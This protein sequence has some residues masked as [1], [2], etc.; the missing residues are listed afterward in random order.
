MTTQHRIGAPGATRRMTAATRRVAGVL[1]L[2]LM[3]VP[4]GAA[5]AQRV[6]PVTAGAGSALA[7]GAEGAL[8]N[9]ALLALEPRREVIVAG[10][11]AG[12]QSDA[13]SWQDYTRYNGK[14]WTD[15]DKNEIL[16]R[17]GPDGVTVRA[18]AGL[19]AL[20]VS[21]GRWAFATNTQISGSARLPQDAARL[22][23]FGNVEDKT[24]SLDGAAGDG[25]AWSGVQVGYGLP[26][27]DGAG[28]WQWTAGVTAKYVKGWGYA[29]ILEATGNLSTTLDGTIGSGRMAVRTARGGSGYSLDLGLAAQAGPRQTWSLSLCEAIS[30]VSWSGD[31]QLQYATFEAVDTPLVDADG[32]EDVVAD[33]TWSVPT[34]GFDAALPRVA[35]L[36]GAFPLGRADVAASLSVRFGAETAARTRMAAG[37]LWPLSGLLSLGG[38]VSVGGSEE[39]SSVAG[40][41]FKSA[42]LRADLALASRGTPLF[43]QARGYGLSLGVGFSY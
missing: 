42:R 4:F 25:L 15:A 18:D 22:L 27:G 3:L 9:P 43:W 17:I 32:T 28:G 20:A 30:R 21:Y 29:R 39:S 23:L 1:L 33:S 24:F 13:F 10:A 37:V 26:V 14:S 16:E 11:Q 8:L 19:A 36:A 34:V 5:R 6:T 7:R 35:T 2:V 40:V 31:P 38:G 12:A 41:T